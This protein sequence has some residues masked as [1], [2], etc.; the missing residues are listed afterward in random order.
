MKT[1]LFLII[2]KD[3]RLIKDMGAWCSEW[4]DACEAEAKA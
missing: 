3:T 1:F 2:V 4:I